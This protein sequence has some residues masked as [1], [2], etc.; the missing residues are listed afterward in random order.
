MEIKLTTQESEKFFHNALC[1]HFGVSG[2][3]LEFSISD[4]ARKKARKTLQEKLDR[5]EIPHTMMTFGTQITPTICR[6]D[7]WMEV[8]AN[9]D[10][11]DIIDHEGGEFNRSITLKDVHERVA[12]TPID[13]LTNMIQE[14]D[15]A[16]TADMIFQTVFFEDIVFG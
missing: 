5:K 10:T 1:N 4:K 3:G 9:G 6:E 7:V 2:Y 16:D 13:H 8:L 15:D 11:L 14:Q 12:K